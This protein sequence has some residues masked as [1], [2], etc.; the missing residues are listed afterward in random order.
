MKL[1]TTYG[2]LLRQFHGLSW[3]KIWRKVFVDDFCFPMIL[4]FAAFAIVTELF[5]TF[6]SVGYFVCIISTLLYS[7][8]V[9]KIVVEYKR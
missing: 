1:H 2:F 4:P 5:Q 8:P 6:I 7:A 9:I 3:G